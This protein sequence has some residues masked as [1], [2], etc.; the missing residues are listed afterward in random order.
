LK[1]SQL[2][3]TGLG[4]K[5]GK[6]CT[7]S[8]ISI[9]RSWYLANKPANP[10]N[11]EAKPAPEDNFVNCLFKALFSSYFHKSLASHIDAKFEHN[12]QALHRSFRRR[13]LAFTAAQQRRVK[14]DCQASALAKTCEYGRQ[15]QTI[16]QTCLFGFWKTKDGS[17]AFAQNPEAFTLGDKDVDS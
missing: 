13:R 2:S 3:Q 7:I 12:G 6:S 14:V 1:S 16:Y 9:I 8:I 5:A 4:K 10:A 11:T 17:A 15:N